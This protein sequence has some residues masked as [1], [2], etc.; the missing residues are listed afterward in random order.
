LESGGDF[1]GKVPSW[2]ARQQAEYTAKRYHQPQDEI[3]PWFSMAGTIQQIR[4][5]LRTPL[6]VADGP[7]QPAWSAGSEFRAA[8]EARVR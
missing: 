1:V 8:G 2:G 6:A 4:V 5:I 3:Q 7:T